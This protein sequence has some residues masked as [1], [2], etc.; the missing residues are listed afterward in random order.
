[1]DLKRADLNVGDEPDDGGDRPGEA[2]K[3]LHRVIERCGIAPDLDDQFTR[4]L[5]SAFAGSA[6]EDPDPD[7]LGREHGVIQR[8]LAAFLRQEAGGCP[9]TQHHD[10]RRRLCGVLVTGFGVH[11]RT[12]GHVV[13][14]IASGFSLL[15]HY[16]PV[17]GNRRG[18]PAQAVL[19]AF[20]TIR[21]RV[22]R[23]RA[24]QFWYHR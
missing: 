18:V 24:Q 8:G 3:G 4:N 20:A 2:A 21:R 13:G 5:I 6:G 12:I 23:R 10:T 17:T 9:T 1:M 7:A 11:Q 16:H 22:V 14:G 15:L 19:R